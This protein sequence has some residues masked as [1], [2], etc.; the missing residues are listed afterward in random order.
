[1]EDSIAVAIR[2]I[3]KSLLKADWWTHVQPEV[4]ERLQFVI[5]NLNSLGPTFKDAFIA[6]F[7]F[8]H[9]RRVVSGTAISPDA[10][11]ALFG[12][13]MTEE[14][15][16]SGIDGTKLL[17]DLQ[18]WTKP[19]DA[20]VQACMYLCQQIGVLSQLGLFQQSNDKEPT[21]SD[22]TKELFSDIIDWPLGKKSKKKK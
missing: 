7:K 2:S 18:D 8:A 22:V 11:G 21:E 9:A 17:L 10:P 4:A 1:M 5:D 15:Y 3:K 19:N 6:S 14:C 16:Q 12:R 20:D 13:N